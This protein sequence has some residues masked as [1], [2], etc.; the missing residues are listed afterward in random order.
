MSGDPLRERAGEVAERREQRFGGP[1][2]S[3]TPRG[4]VGGR[5]AIELS[6]PDGNRYC[7]KNPD[8]L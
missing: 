6:S 7:P 3:M 5:Y 2:F 1:S 4:A 8:D